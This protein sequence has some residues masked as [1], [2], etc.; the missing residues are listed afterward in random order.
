MS[1]GTRQI[2]YPEL[3]SIHLDA[4]S[5]PAALTIRGDSGTWNS[6]RRCC[7]RRDTASLFIALLSRWT[8]LFVPQGMKLTSSCQ[9]LLYF[10]F[11]VDSTHLVEFGT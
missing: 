10:F 9:F 6:A 2:E 1:K 4:S 8:A 5:A 11:I 7:I 3:H